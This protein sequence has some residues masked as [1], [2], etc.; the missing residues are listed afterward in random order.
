MYETL[1]QKTKLQFHSNLGLSSGRIINT[2][3]CNSKVNLFLIPEVGSTGE[4]KLDRCVL[5]IRFI[6]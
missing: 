1:F 3:D 4:S 6:V 2:D 5:I